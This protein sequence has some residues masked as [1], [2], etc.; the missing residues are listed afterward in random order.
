VSQVA[1]KRKLVLRNERVRVVARFREEGSVLGETQHGTCEGFSI[2][3]SLDSDESEEAIVKLIRLAHRMCFTEYALSEAVP[4][5]T[6]HHLNG[7]PIAVR[8]AE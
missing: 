7:R 8:L 3:L 2:E 1:A 5:S 6:I 4:T